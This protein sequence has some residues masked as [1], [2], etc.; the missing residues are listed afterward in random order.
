MI[1]KKGSA[2]STKATKSKKS[3]NRH[4]V[5]Q[6]GGKDNGV[7]LQTSPIT[8]GGGSVSI[9]FDHEWFKKDNPDRP[10]QYW[11]RNDVIEKLWITDN[12]GHKKY[13]PQATKGS[14]ITIHC[15][16]KNN[17]SDDYPIIISTSPLGVEFEGGEYPYSNSKQVHSCS[18]RKITAV[19]VTGTADPIF[20]AKGGKC[21]IDIDDPGR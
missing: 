21:Q 15:V 19:C 4:S 2:K 3:G 17:S 10:K 7:I 5:N 8:I 14:T 20:V 13:Y 16:N 18:Y 12:N 11:N 6:S 9:D 1:K